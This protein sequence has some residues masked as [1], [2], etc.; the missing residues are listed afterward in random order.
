M[1]TA[2]CSP[3][4]AAETAHLVAGPSWARLRVL[5]PQV[6][7]KGRR[8]QLLEELPR[9]AGGLAEVAR[10]KGAVWTPVL[11]M[12]WGDLSS[13]PSSCTDGKRSQAWEAI[14]AGA[15]GTQSPSPPRKPEQE[16]PSASL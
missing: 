2:C 7:E 14:G 11:P 4:P 6:R 9:Q 12:S 1:R 13:S 3:G 8:P 16:G 10:P 15:L 5:R